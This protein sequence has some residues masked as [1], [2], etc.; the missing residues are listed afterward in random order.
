MYIHTSVCLSPLLGH[1]VR[2]EAQPARSEAQTDSQ[3]GLWLQ[4]WLT[5]PQDWLDGPEG[6]EG[7]TDGL[8]VGQTERQ[9]NDRATASLPLPTRTRLTQMMSYSQVCLAV[10]LS[11]CLSVCL[12]L[13]VCCSIGRLFG[14][15]VI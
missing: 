9:I 3:P 15:S 6:P 5:A 8:T 11:N 14:C 13:S 12:A 2:P 7:G 10:C 4:N 1:P